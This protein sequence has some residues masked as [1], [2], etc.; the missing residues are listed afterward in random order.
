MIKGPCGTIKELLNLIFHNI[1]SY[2][3]YPTRN[4]SYKQSNYLAYLIVKHDVNNGVPTT[5]TEKI[6]LCNNK[7]FH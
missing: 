3:F 6:N 7:F 1:S 4:N 2:E 5:R